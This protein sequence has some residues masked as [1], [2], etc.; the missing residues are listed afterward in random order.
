MRRSLALLTTSLL[1]AT[2]LLVAAPASA[3]DGEVVR[4]G[5]CSARSDWKIKAHHDD[6][7]IEWEL[8]VDSPRAGQTWRVRVWDNG[9]RVFAGQ[10]TTN[11]RSGSFEVERTTRNR[12]GVD[13]LV[14]RTLN[15]RTGETCR[16]VVRI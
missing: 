12:A 3:K 13:K 9:T 2:P 15:L 1:A 7:G 11:A 14:G 16:A 5:S 6:G 8:E 4:T 10:R